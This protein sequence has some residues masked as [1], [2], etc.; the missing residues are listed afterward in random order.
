MS[1]RS[2]LRRVAKL[3]ARLPARQAPTECD[4]RYKEA[5]LLLLERMDDTHAAMVIADLERGQFDQHTTNLTMAV[6]R[7]V[8]EHLRYHLP[9]ELPTAVAAVY[10]QNPDAWARQE[11][12][13]CGY[14]LPD[15]FERCPL[16]GGAVSMMAYAFYAKHGYSKYDVRAPAREQGVGD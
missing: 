13:D 16:C 6:A 5:F 12:A 14:D 8:R 2:L 3:E 1:T 7:C 15:G 11:C 4:R 10:A 9:L